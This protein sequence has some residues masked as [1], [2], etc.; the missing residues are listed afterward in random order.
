MAYASSTEGEAMCAGV[1]D[2][3]SKCL[4]GFVYGTRSF[5]PDWRP[6]VAI[7]TASSGPRSVV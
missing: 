7:T 2:L 1:G 5:S 3:A 4:R 6:K